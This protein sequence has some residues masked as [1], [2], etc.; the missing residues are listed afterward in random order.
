MKL[1]RLAIGATAPT[2]F[3]T[4]ALAG[5]ATD[6]GARAIEHGYAAYL[7][8]AVVEKGVLSV[9]PDG[10]GYVVHWDLQKAIDLSD[11]PKGAVTVERFEYRLAPAGPGAWN[12]KA[13][14]F[15][16]IAFNAPTDKGHASGELAYANF[17]LDGLFDPAATPY[18]RLTSLADS[19]R[20]EMHM[21][22]GGD[23]TGM[24]LEQQTLRME[25]RA[26]TA[27]DGK[28]ID[29]AVAQ[30]VGSFSQSV[31]APRE[32]GA[33]PQPLSYAA[34]ASTG[35]LTIKGLRGVELADLWKFGVAHSG[36]GKTPGD[37]KARI[38]STF[39]LWREL[40]AKADINEL[41]V[42][43]PEG[44]GKM[45]AFRETLG[46]TGLV[47]DG[48]GEFGVEIE[49]L[50]LAS[51]LAPPW[52]GSLFP[53]SL[54]L[55]LQVSSHGWDQIGAIVLEDLDLHPD[56]K[57][58]DDAE[59]KIQRVFLSGQP[60]LILR[61]GRLKIPTLDLTYEG[62][63]S[64]D[65]GQPG[66]KAHITAGSLE[67]TIAL[68]QELAADSPDIQSAMLGVAFVKGLAKTGADGRLVWDIQVDGAGGV[69]VNGTPMPTK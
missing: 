68:M 53:A 55:S 17:K 18:L 48:S 56:S 3:A 28:G 10:D 23:H 2:L 25:T 61:P 46:L 22:E 57:L 59:A 7:T 64:L 49:D 47:P 33:E 69:T 6:E 35:E 24:K 13:D 16:R 8:P 27:D 58:S 65:K 45:K 60:K 38:A 62:E 54:S 52:T 32:P 42:D 44:T 29:F 31:T 51:P 43:M 30:A 26:K 9:T 41:K 39:P 63:A 14:R 66:G 12:V 50:S 67:K 37:L 11:A 21:A 36:D 34:S 19:L 20:G 40:R 4:A 1:I 5:S 15:P